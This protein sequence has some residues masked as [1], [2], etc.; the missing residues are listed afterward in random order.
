MDDSGLIERSREGDLDA[1]NQ[2]VE[3]YQRAVYSLALRMLGDRESAEDASQDAFVSAWRSIG[4]F[5]GGSFKAWLLSITANA[6]RDQ[7]RKRKR[8]PTTPLEELLIEPQAGP[9][10]ESPE[11]YALRRELGKQ[12]REGLAS[13]PEEQRL[14]VVLFDMEGLT[15]EEMSQVMRCSIGTVRSRLSRGRLRL[16]DYMVRKGTLPPGISSHQL[17]E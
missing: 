14:A 6:C 15:Y 8:N 2:L 4:R 10:Q 13:L 9:S 11:D 17:E 5:K 16:R 3:R 12:I 7:L 1:F